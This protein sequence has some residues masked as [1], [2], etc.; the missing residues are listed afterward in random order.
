VRQP[1]RERGGWVA[2]ARTAATAA[3]VA[4]AIAGGLAGCS[5]PRANI[6]TLSPDATLESTGAPVTAGIV[7][8]PVTVPELV[9]RP[10]IVTRVSDTEVSVNEF[11]RWGAP[12]KNGIGLT[13]AAD[14]GRL[15]GTAQVSL[16]EQS[17]GVRDNCRVRV[18]IVRFDSVPGD[19]VTIDALW[20]IAVPG[21]SAAITGHTAVHEMVAG[22]GY[23]ALVA[24]HSRALAAVSRDIAMAVRNALP[25]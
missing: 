19:S 14:L 10:Q 18:D 9:D 13:I 6:Y 8:G 21:R 22:A 23:D 11:A 3:G 12:L 4:L 7:V 16:S 5:S 24:A 25:R 2:I 17:P 20:A 15:L 1:G